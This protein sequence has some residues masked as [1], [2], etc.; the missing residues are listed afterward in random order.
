MGGGN[1]SLP[2]R[3]KK[4]GFWGSQKAGS[5]REMGPPRA[6]RNPEQAGSDTDRH[7]VAGHLLRGI[8][9]CGS[10]GEMIRR[11]VR[12]FPFRSGGPSAPRAAFGRP[13]VPSILEKNGFRKP[14]VSPK[15]HWVGA[16][17][18]S[19][20]GVKNLGFGG[21]KKRVPL[22]KWGLPGPPEIQNRRGQTRTATKL[23]DIYLGGFADAAVGAR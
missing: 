4:F 10:G 7:K 13:K 8:R 1:S 12:Q 5:P 2:A 3:G 20:R 14:P 17:R 22:G 11:V 18:A 15:N 9:R 19:P 21:P 23:Q 16:I 6:P